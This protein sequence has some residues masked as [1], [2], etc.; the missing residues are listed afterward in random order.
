MINAP[1]IILK[2]RVYVSWRIVK[3]T[4]LRKFVMTNVN[5]TSSLTISVRDVKI[6]N[7]S[8]KTSVYSVSIQSSSFKV[9]A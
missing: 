2:K 8:M 7:V 9:N 6:V 5:E 3:R 1:R 4:S